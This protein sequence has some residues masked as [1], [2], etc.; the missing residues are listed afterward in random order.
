MHSLR[1]KQA[2]LCVCRVCHCGVTRTVLRFVP[3]VQTP[4]PRLH[5][6][7]QA[8]VQWGV[9]APSPLPWLYRMQPLECC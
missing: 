6:N 2:F 7:G 1:Q 8:N 4:L 9:T 3:F 5:M